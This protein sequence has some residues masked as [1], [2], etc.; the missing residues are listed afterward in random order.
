M[1]AETADYIT[2]VALSLVLYCLHKV[3]T[4][5]SVETIESFQLATA[6]SLS[7]K[8][9]SYIPKIKKIYSY[10]ALVFIVKTMIPYFIK[11]FNL[12]TSKGQNDLKI[13]R[14]DG[15]LLMA[16]ILMYDYAM[17]HDLRKY[18][19]SRLDENVQLVLKAD[20]AYLQQPD[21][22]R[23][24]L[25]KIFI[26]WKTLQALP[27]PVYNGVKQLV[28][29]TFQGMTVNQPLPAGLT[30]QNI[31]DWVLD[32]NRMLYSLF[33]DVISNMKTLI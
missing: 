17:I 9:N 14:D 11:L 32:P 5:K 24:A 20:P 26:F 22:Y 27:S 12:G 18:D 10:V 28:K 8:V 1:F 33:A 7:I 31:T 2:I 6:Q 23:N 4:K 16:F 25:F 13:W 3:P 29:T 30:V 19:T 21:K 15:S